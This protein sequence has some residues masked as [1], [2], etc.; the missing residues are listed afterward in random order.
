MRYVTGETRRHMEPSP[1]DIRPHVTLRA[2]S[3]D[4]VG[5]QKKPLNARRGPCRQGAGTNL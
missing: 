1:A 3:T 2:H 5:L 4:I